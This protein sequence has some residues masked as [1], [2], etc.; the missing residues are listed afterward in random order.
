MLDISKVWR[1]A[2]VKTDS[3]SS[4]ELYVLRNTVSPTSS[5]YE[6]FIEVGSE[7]IPT[8]SLG[9]KRQFKK[10][11]LPCNE[12]DRILWFE[13][14][15]CRLKLWVVPNYNREIGFF[16]SR[17]S[18][19]KYNTYRKEKLWTLGKTLT[20]NIATISLHKKVFVV[21]HQKGEKQFVRRLRH[22]SIV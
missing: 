4:N 11:M 3:T 1:I 18:F 19:H 12:R 21:A 13:P 16:L 8:T 7:A 20:G 14:K 22:C 15:G 17:V 9:G 10:R 5:S 6:Y 2:G